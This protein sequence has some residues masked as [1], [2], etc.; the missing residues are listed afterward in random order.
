MELLQKLYHLRDLQEKC[1]AAYQKYDV[2]AK[3]NKYQYGEISI[4][5]K[6]RKEMKRYGSK[7]DEYLKIPKN[8]NAM[9]SYRQKK[10]YNSDDLK[11]TTNVVLSF[12]LALCIFIIPLIFKFT[13]GRLILFFFIAAVS[14]P[15]LYKIK[16]FGISILIS[17]IKQSTATNS[18]TNRV[19]K[20][21]T[22]RERIYRK[23]FD[24]Q[25]KYAEEHFFDDNQKEIELYNI[26]KDAYNE[27]NYY[28]FLDNEIKYLDAII[29]KIQTKRADTIKEALQ[30]ID[31][32]IANQRM[33]KMIKSEL[34]KQ[35][36]AIKNIKIN[37]EYKFDTTFN[38][39]DN[40]DVKV[41]VH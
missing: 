6:V 5:E 30:L 11:D 33:K 29:N 17:H 26:W 10:A 25:K 4:E 39:Y 3:K 38:Y 41:D 31:N 32:D 28:N 35:T 16:C 27:L 8:Q 9:P 2:Q 20:F 1:I 23:Y 40:T 13:I 18:L 12:I 37:N 24:E 34:E 21:H 36:E 22:E 19:N 7:Y 14:V 15:I